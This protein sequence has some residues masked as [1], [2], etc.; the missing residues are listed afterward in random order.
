[1]ATILIATTAAAG[2]E[3]IEPD[4]GRREPP[5]TAF[6]MKIRGPFGS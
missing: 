4:S 2:L 3:S 6:R 1:M 5:D